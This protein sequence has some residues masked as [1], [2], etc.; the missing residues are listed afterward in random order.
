MSW[1]VYLCGGVE[2]LQLAIIGLLAHRYRRLQRRLDE[3]L[4]FARRPPRSITEE[5]PFQHPAAPLR[6]AAGGESKFDAVRRA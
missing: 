2:L 6:E 3:D 4:R 5:S 1:Y